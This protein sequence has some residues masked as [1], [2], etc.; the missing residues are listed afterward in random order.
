MHVEVIDA[1]DDYERPPPISWCPSSGERNL[2]CLP[3]YLTPSENC[4]ECGA[5]FVEL[6]EVGFV[7]PHPIPGLF[8]PED[9]IISLHPRPERPSHVALWCYSGHRVEV[10]AHTRALK[11][12]PLW[13]DATSVSVVPFG[14]VYAVMR[15]RRKK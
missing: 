1:L 10:T 9:W 5:V 8:H 3:D 11:Y 6:A 13:I 12:A 14:V 7:S 2:D 15:G 4:P